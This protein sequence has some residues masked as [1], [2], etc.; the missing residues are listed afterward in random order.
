MG[1]G[2][3]T[4]EFWEYKSYRDVRRNLAYYGIIPLNVAGFAVL[5]YVMPPEHKDK[6][7]QI[8]GFVH[9]T[10]HVTGMV[11]LSLASFALV[12][13][14]KMHDGWY[15]NYF[16]RWRASY[17]IDFILPRLCLPFLS[18]LHARF[19]EEAER[20]V[21]SSWKGCFTPSWGMR[22]RRYAKAW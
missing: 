10:A 8:V 7:E 6:I 16:V 19:L 15:D 21:G 4:M 3:I 11:L 1:A 17:A 2:G 18:R 20:N 9:V 12:E 5:D 22:N 14:V 13:L